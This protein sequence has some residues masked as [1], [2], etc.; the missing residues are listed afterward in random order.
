MPVMKRTSVLI[1]VF[2]AAF[3]A[4]S[5][6]TV[7]AQQAARSA[8]DGVYAADQAK[9]GETFYAET[10]AACHDPALIGGIG[11]AL[12][13]KDF[14]AAWKDKTVGDVFTKI[15]VEMPQTAP[16]TLTPEQ[17]A[18]VLS[19]ILSVNR[20]PAGAAP[21]ATD[22]APLNDIH[23]VEPAAA[24]AATAPAAATADA[25]PAATAPVAAA[26][27]GGGLYADAQAQR[28]QAVYVDNCAACHGPMLG[29][30][31]GPALAGPR[32][33]ARWKDKSIADVFDKIKTT[34]P[35][36]APGSLT[37]EQTA[38]VL[39]LVLSSN[40]YPGGAAELT[41][42]AAPQKTAPLGEPPQQ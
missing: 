16:G 35:A 20:F 17:T 2:G 26:G 29:G 10:C 9:R 40:H 21:L 11:P 28:G 1:I 12:A 31:I 15:K 27:G 18:D 13:G 22:A 36:S 8:N 38:D 33:V 14:I 7:R 34:M 32:F 25:A 30:D 4:A 23:I 24:G 3:A 19:Y 6:S 41:P 39:A 37:P 42:E 5:F